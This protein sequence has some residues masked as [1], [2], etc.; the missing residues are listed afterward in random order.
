MAAGAHERLE[1]EILV[2]MPERLR[3]AVRSLITALGTTQAQSLTEIRIREGASPVLVCRGKEVSGPTEGMFRATAE[4]L[5]R[6]FNIISANSVHAFEEEIR[7]GYVTVRGGHRIGMAG[8]AIV[9]GGKVR[10]MKHIRSYNIRIARD[11][12]GA[13]DSL[14]SHLVHQG[15]VLSSL[16]A[17]HPGS[18]KTTVLRELTRVFSNGMPARGIA[19]RNVGVVDERSEIA[20]CYAG[21]PQNDVGPRTDVV[22]CC[23]K[24]EGMM[25]LIRAM[26][27][28]VL[29]TDEIGSPADAL[30]IME[31][32][33]SGVSVL[34]SAHASS[35]SDLMTRPVLSRLIDAGA[36]QRI[37]ILSSRL[38]PGTV[39]E[40]CDG[41]GALI[42]S[43][44]GGLYN[45][46]ASST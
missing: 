1:T 11:C 18:G 13:A 33:N 21:T 3:S 42:S 20:G 40:I 10:S 27:P 41:R 22:D 43:A 17:G 29:V 26:S 15:Q 9:D 31:A 6:M 4:D 44:S 24:A 7:K 16:I 35:R 39:E 36:F 45:E 34:A 38:G 37:V 25:M 23:P 12:T 5:S 30:A 19:P 8:K 14:L 2:H 28:D 32:L 46:R